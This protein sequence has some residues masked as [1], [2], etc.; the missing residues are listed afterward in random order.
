ML[1]NFTDRIV[2]NHATNGLPFPMQ[3]CRDID[4][5]EPAVATNDFCLS[6]LD[7]I[8]ILSSNP[9][10][11]DSFGV[12]LHQTSGE[13]YRGKRLVDG[14]ERT[15]EKPRLLT[16]NYRQTVCLAQSLNI[17]ERLGA[18]APRS[19]HRLE[20]VAQNVAV[21]LMRRQNFGRARGQL[22]METYRG[23]VELLECQ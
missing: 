1:N 13:L 3:L 10:H 15:G 19:V 21:S 18:G 20:R 9:E 22:V 8:V 7:E 12:A 16:G 11:R 4:A 2:E 5:G 6:H 17:R 23:R 14:V